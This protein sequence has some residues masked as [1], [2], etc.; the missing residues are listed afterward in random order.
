MMRQIVRFTLAHKDDAIYL[1]FVVGAALNFLPQI[2]GFSL[3]DPTT[4]EYPDFLTNLASV[5][6][7]G[8]LTASLASTFPIV[9]DYV[10][11]LMDN[12]S[13]GEFKIYYRANHNDSAHNFIPFRE[14]ALL[15]VLPDLLYLFWIIPYEQYD[16]MAGLIGLRD[17]MYI[18]SLMTYLFRF[19]NPIWTWSSTMLIAG[20]LMTANVLSTCGFLSVDPTFVTANVYILLFLVALGLLTLLVSL[21]RWFWYILTI[22][23]RSENEKRRNYLCTVYAV[24]STIFI[25]GD[26][27]IFFAP[28]PIEP[29]WSNM[30]TNYLTLYTYLMAFCTVMVTVVTTRTNREDSKNTKVDSSF[31][32]VC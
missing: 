31:H 7:V 30:G 15:L 6:Y 28:Q 1:L 23:P 17:T 4:G 16:Y 24:C 22:T 12:V 8:S 20:S 25:L 29:D 26:W 32:V 10:L 21:V 9:I 27:L 3:K 13:H 18:Y 2:L 19:G 11:D 5:T 14:V